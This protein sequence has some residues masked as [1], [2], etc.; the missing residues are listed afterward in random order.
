MLTEP[1]KKIVRIKIFV[2][3]S[4][5]STKRG[6]N[7]SARADLQVAGDGKPFCHVGKHVK[8]RIEI[9]TIEADRKMIFEL[10]FFFD[11]ERPVAF[12]A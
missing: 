4:L 5:E 2:H 10:R 6:R 8:L 9:A 3:G 1:Y 11:I 12:D 7:Y